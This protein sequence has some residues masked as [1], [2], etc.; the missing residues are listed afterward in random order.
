MPNVVQRSISE[1]LYY[2]SHRHSEKVQ[3]DT[4]KPFL[5]YIDSLTI[6]SYTPFPGNFQLLTRHSKMRAA[7]DES[8]NK[9]TPC[10]FL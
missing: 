6:Y 10:V 8:E 2:L 9:H 7:K 5:V 3:N 4:F 1:I